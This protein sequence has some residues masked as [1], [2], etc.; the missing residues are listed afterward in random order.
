[1]R[2]HDPV[3]ATRTVPDST[4]LA[5]SWPSFCIFCFIFSSSRNE[6]ASDFFFTGCDMPAFTPPEK[7]A[8]DLQR[9]ACWTRFPMNYVEGIASSSS[10]PSWVRKLSLCWAETN[11]HL[12][13]PTLSRTLDASPARLHNE[14]SSLHNGAFSWSTWTGSKES[15]H[16]RRQGSCTKPWRARSRLHR[17][18]C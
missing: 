16:G 3:D 1:M 14:P 7:S 2:W 9:E 4:F 13:S 10:P 8:L 12:N 5:S 17:S 6:S 11:R 15:R 18:L